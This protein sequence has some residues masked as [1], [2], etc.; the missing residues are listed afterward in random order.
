MEFDQY[1]DMEEEGFWFEIQELAF[2]VNDIIERYGLEDRVMSSIVVGVLEP[3]NENTSA[4]KAFFHHNLENDEEVEALCGFMQDSYDMNKPDID[5][6]LD[7]LGISL[8]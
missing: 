4:M 1:K 3:L 2:T 7:G 5:D 8:N 6:L